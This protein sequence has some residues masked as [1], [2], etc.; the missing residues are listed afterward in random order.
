MSEAFFREAIVRL[1]RLQCA[2]RHSFYASNLQDDP[3]A[4][5]TAR[6]QLAAAQAEAVSILNIINRAQKGLKK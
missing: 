2:L 4:A 5:Q 6:Q 1:D 3:K